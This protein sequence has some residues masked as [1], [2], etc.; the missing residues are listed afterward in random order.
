MNNY[1]QSNYNIVFENDNDGVWIY[2]T[3]SGD[4]F[5]LD[6]NVFYYLK[7]NK[8]EELSK[9]YPDIYN[10][11]IE[12]GSII[13]YNIDEIALLKY[14]NLKRKYSNNM[15]NL[16]LVLTKNCNFDCTYCFERKENSNFTLEV[17]KNILE[18]VKNKIKQIN[19]LNIGWFGGEPLLKMDT[20][21]RL[22]RDFKK[23]SKKYS[24]EYYSVINTNG[25]Y[26]NL[27]NFEELLNVKTRN[28]DITIDGP[29]EYHNKSRPLKGGGETYHRIIS[30]LLEIGN[31]Y[32]I[33]SLSSINTI[34]NLRVNVS[35]KN[36]NILKTWMQNDLPNKLKNIVRI[37]FAPVSIGGE[38]NSN[39]EKINPL[40]TIGSI[41]KYQNI[42]YDLTKF[43]QNLGFLTASGTMGLVPTYTACESEN[44]NRYVIL[45]DGG[46]AKCPIIMNRLGELDK[47]GD[48]I[49]TK[50]SEYIRWMTKDPFTFKGQFKECE[51]CKLLP[52]CV[53]GCMKNIVKTG[54][55]GCSLF[56]NDF[57]EYLKIVKLEK[58]NLLKYETVKG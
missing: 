43:A 9:N 1:K 29:A 40:D 5:K 33:N 27:E 25:Y 31:K 56:K 49:I 19:V 3:F 10:S 57:N 21:K 11:L 54:N 38:K 46:I 24:V 47:K 34:I 13:K 39:A 35:N 17:E 55:K 50:E 36:K 23:I 53:G 58:M 48:I 2:N 32:N 12:N 7:N 52:F 26:L 18:L 51:S 4:M 16:M 42:I 37:Y 22:G 41:G 30:N 14:L 20:I 44:E 45:P 28:F 8:I 15:L 6:D